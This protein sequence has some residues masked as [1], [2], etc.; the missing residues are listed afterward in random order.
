MLPSK[1][2][3]DQ[4]RERGKLTA[5]IEASGRSGRKVERRKTIRQKEQ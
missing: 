1:G 2:N 4:R 5:G 3:E